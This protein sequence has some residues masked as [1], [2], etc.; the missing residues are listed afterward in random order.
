MSL[1]EYQR[2]R[3]F[4]KTPEP[5]PK[6]KSSGKGLQFVV[7]KHA[8]SRLHYD[9]RLELDGTLKSW[10]VPKG[11]SLD[12]SVKAL[13]VHVEDHP[14]DYAG[15]EGV[16]PQG[17]Y[18]GGTVMVWDRGTWEP[19]GENPS[20]AYRQGKLK[21]RLHGE[22]LKGSWA[23][24][25]MGG[26][27][28]EGGKNWL[29]IKHD[30]K[31][32][33]RT[34]DFDVTVKKAKSVVSKR[35]I[36]QIAAAE[37]RV[38]QSDRGVDGDHRKNGAATARR[39]A[40]KAALKK[41]A[42]KAVAMKSPAK[43][44]AGAKR[45]K[46]KV[47]RAARPVSAK[48]AAALPG[49]RPARQPHAFKP[50]LATLSTE[51]PQGDRWVH[52]LKFDGYR[53]LAVFRDGKVRLITRRGN[54]WTQRFKSVADA[55]E[56]LPITQAILDGEVVSLDEKGISNF[57]KLQNQL[58]RGDVQSLA[59]YLFDVPHFEGYDLTDTPLIERKN[60]LQRIL[61][62]HGDPSSGTLRYSEHIEGEGMTVWKEA[63]HGALEGII[64]KRVDSKYQQARSPAWLKT[65]CTRRQEFVIGGF[66]APSGARTHFGALLLGYYDD[67][68]LIYA[69]KVGTGFTAQS[70]G[71]VYRELK[72]RKFDAPPFANPPR[73]YDARGVTWVRPELVAEVE[74]SE[75]TADGQLRIPSFQ[76]LRDDK[77]PL[78]IVREEPKI[79][80]ANATAT[81]TRRQAAAK[82]S[83]DGKSASKPARRRARPTTEEAVV[84]GIRISSPED[85]VY[86]GYGVT[87]L[88]L[89]RYYESV[90]DWVLP[91][92]ERRPLT[93]VR[94]PQGQSRR[95][96][97]QKHMGG[98]MPKAVHGVKIKEKAGTDTYL[99][100]RDIAGV[101]ALVQFRVLEF[102]PWP[103]REDKIERP[104]MLVF[105]LD[106]GEG[107]DWKA[108]VQGAKDARDCLEALGLQTFLRT[109]GG[110]GLHVCAPL[111]RRNTWDELKEFAHGVA[112]TMVR[113]APDRYTANMSKAKRRGKIFV[114]YLRN[115]RG[116]T[117]V[118]S[119]STRAR[120]G[121]P[122]AVPLAW[123]ELS[124]KLKPDKYTVENIHKRLTRGF[125]DPWKDFFQVKQ[126]ITRAMMDAVRG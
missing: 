117:A 82:P 24:V 27:A 52:E 50:Q 55:L 125:K 9:F 122:I 22:K 84:A 89:A 116:A 121:A 7:Q 115:Q 18:G 46:K 103:A 11:P 32:A 99:A 72:P 70:L 45:I 33:R 126:S 92:L 57:Q 105:D 78:Q 42:K 67:G 8:A 23:L 61:A 2:K 87:K 110:K 60:F 59:F 120:T 77:P 108:V 97:F 43:T 31:A 98:A 14:L 36:E 1:K 68:K 49:A 76:G 37:D 91:Y 80:P 95:C 112:D 20:A 114:D 81:S 16:I 19:E 100:V 88:D 83:S 65:K 119:Y 17:Q 21:F 53:M 12:P 111:A 40:K 28:G 3:D 73:G 64:S 74:F 93:L 86:P 104:D 69:G 106:P 5:A 54:D 109:S 38:W 79:M 66:T 118:A 44:R 107:L 101:I 41:I 10:A 124:I 62:A 30:D 34:A 75:W 13:A 51:A 63:C 90:A 102:H 94:C 26:R 47:K 56:E 29:L 35:T 15:F 4:R 96:F 58:K 6:V 25:R 113:A 123:D 48:D 39:T 71:D 85:V